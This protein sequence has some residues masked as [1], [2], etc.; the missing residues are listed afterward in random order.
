MKDTIKFIQLLEEFQKVER[1]MYSHV[2]SKR[3]E[4]DVEHSY[5][6]AMFAWYII[7]AK[8]LKFNISKVLR[9]ALLHDM[10]EVYAGDTFIHSTDKKLTGSK[11][12]REKKAALKLKK[13]F[14]EF[15]A[16]H[17]TIHDY[18]ERKDKESRFVY[19]LDKILPLIKLY[20]DNGR[21][22]KEKKVSFE[23]VVERKVNKVTVSPE[24]KELFDEVVEILRK[25]KKKLFDL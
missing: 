4:H 12:A 13:N 10:V 14:P 23:M 20:L 11:E 18:E 1:V 7:D 6:L 16:M 17:A 24:G 15:P 19:V 3:P 9:Y 2:G 22:W 25:N 8:K 5:E 21:K